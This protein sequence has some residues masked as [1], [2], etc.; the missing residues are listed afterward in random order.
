[1]NDTILGDIE[2]VA[3]TD[4]DL[5][6]TQAPTPFE[7]PS[8]ETLQPANNIIKDVIDALDRDV[9]QDD[10]LTT[11]DFNT[12]LDVSEV[13]S[14]TLLQMLSS[15]GLGGFESSL[16]ARRIQRNRVSLDGKGREEKVRIIQGEREHETGGDQSSI[17]GKI[18][19]FMG[20]GGK[21]EK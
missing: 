10:T 4:K 7:L 2:V 21:S 17:F 20:I 12:R 19:G 5:K 3:I 1:M 16:L 14:I 9:M 18:K 13:P 15:L 8:Q 11:I 6:K